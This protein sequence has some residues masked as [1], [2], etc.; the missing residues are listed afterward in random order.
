VV[1]TTLAPTRIAAMV[2]GAF[3]G[4]ALL[5]AAVGLYGVIAYSVSRRTR[6]VGIRLALGAPRAQVMR[7][8]VWQ[9]GRLAAIGIALGLGIS[10]FV[11]GLLESLLYGVS[12]LDPIAF[13]GAAI[14][15]LMVALAANVIP[16]LTA[17]RVNPVTALRSE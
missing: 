14:L 6:E 9:G 7:M 13:T 16:A 10:A 4:L 8:V 12:G 11:T 3:G 1:A 17:S 5:L 2:L 15:L